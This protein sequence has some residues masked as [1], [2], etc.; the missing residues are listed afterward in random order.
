[1][2]KLGI[3]RGANVIRIV[4]DKPTYLPKPRDLLHED[5]SDKTG[6]LTIDDCSI[7]PD[8]TIPQCI[9]YQQ[10][11]ANKDLKRKFIT[12]IMDEFIKFG[13]DS[14]LSVNIILDYVD[15]EC[16]MCHIRRDQD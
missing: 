1:M 12:Y 8:E 4:V 16:A 11:L 10:M 15:I 14:N 5:R 13:K 6:K 9:K 7:G 2:I 3:Q